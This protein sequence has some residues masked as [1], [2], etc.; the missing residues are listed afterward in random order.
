MLSGVSLSGDHF[1]YPNVLESDGKHERKEWFGCAC[2]PSNIARFIPS[3]PGYV[4]AIDDDGI[5]VNLYMSN[6]ADITFHGKNIHLA[7]ETDYPYDGNIKISVDVE[8]EEDFALLLRIPGWAR[9]E[10]IDGDLYTFR[11]RHDPHFSVLVNG[12][13][14]SYYEEDGYLIINRT[15][16]EG[17]EIFLTLP[18]DVRQLAADERVRSDSAK[19]AFQRGPLV[20]AAEWADNEQYD[21]LDIYSEFAFRPYSKFDSELFGGIPVIEIDAYTGGYSEAQEIKLIPYH[22]WNNRGKGKMQIWIPLVDLPR[23]F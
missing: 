16:G 2:C 11:D 20:Y 12:D 3:V 23:H 7:Q 15:W 19:M 6:E 17:D 1:F 8:K 5:F 22:L 14:S 4:Y 10:A 21:V 9:N 18:M 13:S